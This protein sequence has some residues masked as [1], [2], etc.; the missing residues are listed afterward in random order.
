[1]ME[2]ESDD[3]GQSYRWRAYKSSRTDGATHGPGQGAGQLADQG[4]GEGGQGQG[5][6]ALNAASHAAAALDALTGASLANL[7]RRRM[8]AMTKEVTLPCRSPRF[9]SALSEDCTLHR[10]AVE[11]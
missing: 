3:P 9:P 2:A 11:V 8:H 1:M 5:N 10:R 6:T 4:E 7:H